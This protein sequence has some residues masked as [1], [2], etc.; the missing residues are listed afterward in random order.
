[1]AHQDDV[2]DHA[3]YSSTDPGAIAQDEIAGLLA[4]HDRRRV[5]VERT[6]PGHD[7]RIAHP[8][9]LGPRTRTSGSTTAMPPVPMA[10]APGM[11]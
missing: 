10:H 6:A 8:Q 7:R 4:D 3:A 11:G 1:M 2:A 9:A 5:G